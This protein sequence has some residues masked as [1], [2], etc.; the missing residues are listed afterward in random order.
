MNFLKFNGFAE[1]PKAPWSKYYNENEMELNTP[2][3]SLYTY[4]ENKILDFGA[5]V[6]LDYYDKKVNYNELLSMI[7]HCA[8]GLYNLGVRPGYVVTLCLPNTLE[9]VISF[10][11]INRIG[12][13]VNFIHPSSGENEIKDSVNEM[14]SKVLIA[15]D[16]NYLKI[17]EKRRYLKKM[18]DIFKNQAFLLYFD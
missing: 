8:K 6:C 10:F 17:K 15:V 5:R 18:R 4:F 13:I 7:E 12:A 11:A 16:E 3:C 2:N 14:E 9:G 1:R